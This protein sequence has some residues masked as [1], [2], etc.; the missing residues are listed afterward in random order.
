[1]KCVMRLR[2]KK[3]ALDPR[4]ENTCGEASKQTSGQ[5]C[6]ERTR[7]RIEIRRLKEERID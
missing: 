5:A 3:H 1:M 4:G 6:T 2:G 7:D